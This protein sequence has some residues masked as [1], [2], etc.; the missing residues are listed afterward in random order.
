MK[1]EMNDRE[2]RTRSSSASNKL[3]G[4]LQEL[5]NNPNDRLAKFDQDDVK[6]S[7]TG[8][9]DM[10]ISDHASPEAA[11]SN[12][13]PRK[14]ATGKSP[15]KR[16]RREAGGE[17][18][19]KSGCVSHVMKFRDR[20]VDLAQ[21]DDTTSMYVLCRAWMTNN[22]SQT[23][24]QTE[25]LPLSPSQSQQTQLKPTAFSSSAPINSS[26][27]PLLAAAAA[28]QA[29]ENS[30]EI[31]H[32]PP[33]HRVEQE[34][35]GGVQYKGLPTEPML[36]DLHADQRKAPATNELKKK[37]IERWKKVRSCWRDHLIHKQARYSKSLALLREVWQQ[38]QT[39][40]QPSSERGQWEN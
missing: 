29:E 21:F 32:L 26:V 12:S 1:F 5:I 27:A 37:H 30:K 15:R 24:L 16:R 33:P 25:H 38:H 36:L 19:G 4:L 11:S 34:S 23:A 7:P 17:S 3:E 39:N 18:G 13:T 20:Q 35:D 8:I 14:S 6:G 28:A 31:W 40:L 2:R 10:P 22:P 9:E